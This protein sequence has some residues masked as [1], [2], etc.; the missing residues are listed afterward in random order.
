MNEQCPVSNILIDKNTAR[1]N[2][3]LCT[4]VCLAIAFS[5]WRFLIILLIADFFMRGFVKP[6]YSFF[7]QI[8]RFLLRLLGARPVPENAGPKIFA[9]KIGFL[10]ASLIGLSYLADFRNVSSILMTALVACACL[11]SFFDFCI[12]C[13]IYSLWIKA[14]SRVDERLAV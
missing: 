1:M 3:F 12:G 8:S 4:T 13:K 5:N 7:S 11:E 2:G 14:R 9:S 6:R 10:F